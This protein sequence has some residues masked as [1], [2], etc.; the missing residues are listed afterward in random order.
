MMLSTFNLSVS[1]MSS[2]VYARRLAF[3]TPYR[4]L[5]RYLQ[6]KPGSVVA[7]WLTAV[8]VP[9][10]YVYKGTRIP[11]TSQQFDSKSVSD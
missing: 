5:Q 1:A 11:V 2:R 6:Y 7:K 10:W 8:I 4:L 9:G 3:S